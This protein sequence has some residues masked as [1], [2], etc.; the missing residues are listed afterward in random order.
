[1][2][3]YANVQM[4]Q[5]ILYFVFIHLHICI[6]AYPHIYSLFYYRFNKKQAIFAIQYYKG[7]QISTETTM[8]RPC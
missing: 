3:K 2:C 8:L 4:A 5:D 1:M 7:Y 6:S